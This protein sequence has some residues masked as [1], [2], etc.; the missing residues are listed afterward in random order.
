MFYRRSDLFG[1]ARRLCGRVTALG[2]FA[3]ACVMFGVGT[4]EA[5][6]TIDPNSTVPGTAPQP[7]N[8]PFFPG[9]GVIVL[10]SPEPNLAEYLFRYRCCATPGTP[11]CPSDDN[12]FDVYT[13]VPL[14]VEN[15][16]SCQLISH[17]DPNNGNFSFRPPDGAVL[18]GA[19]GGVNVNGMGGNR[20]NEL[21]RAGDVAGPSAIT[22]TP[23]LAAAGFKVEDTTDLVVELPGQDFV[24]SRTF[25]GSSRVIKTSAFGPHALGGWM[26]STDIQIVPDLVPAGSQISEDK[27]NRSGIALLVAAPVRDSIAFQ[28]LTK[29][30]PEHQLATTT[31]DSVLPT[32]A[33][34][35]DSDVLRTFRPV[36]PGMMR[37]IADKHTARD[38]VVPTPAPS[39]G[40]Q[41][42]AFVP[43]DNPSNVV[44]PVWRLVDPGNGTSIFFR[45]DQRGTAFDSGLAF[46]PGASGNG[47]DDV[48]NDAAAE[49]EMISKLCG[50]YLWQQIDAYGNTW[51]YEYTNFQVSDGSTQPR[52]TAIYLHGKSKTDSSTRAI[53]RFYWDYVKARNNE[54]VIDESDIFAPSV[55]GKHLRIRMVTVERPVETV[56]G[57]NS[58]RSWETTDRI[59]YYY[60]GNVQ[61]HNIAGSDSFRGLGSVGDLVMVI[62]RT[63]AGQSEAVINIPESGGQTNRIQSWH[64]RITQYRMINTIIPT[65]GTSAIVSKQI[66]SVFSPEQIELLAMENPRV[67]DGNGDRI[68][69][70]NVVG[71]SYADL[72]ENAAWGLLKLP[73]REKLKFRSSPV[74]LGSWSQE[75]WT[76]AAKWLIYYNQPGFYKVDG[77]GYSGPDSIDPPADQNSL[78]F[79]GRVREELLMPGPRGHTLRKQHNYSLLDDA[80]SD[81]KIISRTSSQ[82][83]GE[84]SQIFQNTITYGLRSSIT[85]VSEFTR[86]TNQP[87]LQKTDLWSVASAAWQ[88]RRRVTH[89]SEERELF[90]FSWL[91]QGENGPATN[92]W[93]AAVVPFTVAE[94]VDE[95]DANGS[96]VVSGRTWLTYYE[97]DKNNRPWR[98][99]DPGALYSLVGDLGDDANAPRMTNLGSRIANA[100][101]SSPGLFANA[102]GSISS[103]VYA[104]YVQPSDQL[105]EQLNCVHN[106]PATMRVASRFVGRRDSLALGDTN[107]AN[108]R[109][110]TRTKYHNDVGLLNPPIRGINYT[111]TGPIE[112]R[113]DLPTEDLTFTSDTG[114][115]T[116]DNTERTVYTWNARTESAGSGVHPALK[117]SRVQSVIVQ[118]EREL[119]G[120][121]GPLQSGGRAVYT[122]TWLDEI[123]RVRA[124]SVYSSASDTSAP[125]S[126]AYSYGFGANNQHDLTGKPTAVRVGVTIGAD[127]DLLPIEESTQTLT[128]RSVFDVSGNLIRSI[129]PNGIS[130]DVI[131]SVQ[132]LPTSRL[133]GLDSQAMPVSVLV[134]TVIPHEMS[135][136]ERPTEGLSLAGAITQEWYNAAFRPLRVTTHALTPGAVIARSTNRTVLAVPVLDPFEFSRADTVYTFSGLSM[137]S[138]TWAFTSQNPVF[139]SVVPPDQ[140]PA[141]MQV[142]DEP[143]AYVTRSDY[144]GDGNVTRS[145]DPLGNVFLSKYDSRARLIQTHRGIIAD[146]GDDTTLVEERF[147]DHQTELSPPNQNDIGDGLLTFIKTYPGNGIAPRSVK[148]VYDARKRL[149][150]SF[151][152]STGTNPSFGP[153]SLSLYD[154]LDRV[155]LK[156][157]LSESV[158]HSAAALRGWSESGVLASANA[159][160][161]SR[162]FYSQRGFPFR[163]QS[164]IGGGTQSE[165]PRWSTVD[166]WFDAIGR[167]LAVSS[168]GG[169]T[170]K[171]QYDA[172]GQL[173]RRRSV[174]GGVANYADALHIDKGFGLEET[175]TERSN[176][177]TLTRLVTRRVRVDAD[178]PEAGIPSDGMPIG[179]SNAVS[180][181]AATYYDFAARPILTINYGTNDTSASRFSSI[182]VAAPLRRDTPIK[183]MLDENLG[184]DVPQHA[185]VTGVWYDTRGYPEVSAVKTG[186]DAA[187]GRIQWRVT[188][189]LTDSLG[190]VYAVIENATDADLTSTPR[191]SWPSAGSTWVRGSVLAGT[192]DQNRL[193]TT[194]FDSGGQVVRT[195]A[196][197]G[198]FPEA[199]QTTEYR[200]GGSAAGGLSADVVSSNSTL[201]E[202]RY[203]DPN[204][205]EPS[206]SPRDRVAYSYNG[207]GEQQ[208][209][210]DQNGTIR[211]FTRDFQG[212]VIADTVQEFG[213]PVLVGT[214]PNESSTWQIDRRVSQ[215][216]TKFDEF[217][218][219]KAVASTSWFNNPST[220]AVNSGSYSVSNNVDPTLPWRA[221]SGSAINTSDKLADSV[222]YEY[223][224]IGLVKTIR[225]STVGK[226]PD[227][228]A[229][230]PQSP[231]TEGV[232]VVEHDYEIVPIAGDPIGRASIRPKWMKYPDIDTGPLSA[233]D[234]TYLHTLYAN[235]FHG[236]IDRPTKLAVTASSSTPSSSTPATVEYKRLGSGTFVETHF[237]GGSKVRM[238]R[239]TTNTPGLYPGWDSFGRLR[240]YSWSRLVSLPNNSTARQ[241][242]YGEQFR[243]DILSRK[244]TSFRTMRN[245]GFRS[246]DWY[247]QYDALDRVLSAERGLARTTFTIGGSTHP[248]EEIA[249][250]SKQWSLD[251]LGNWQNEQTVQGDGTTTTSTRAHNAT[252]EVTSIGDESRLYD[253]NGNVVEVVQAGLTPASRQRLVYDAWNR[254]VLREVY[255]GAVP[256]GSNNHLYHRVRQQYNALNWRTVET[257]EPAQIG[258]T[259]PQHT[260]RRFYYS[261]AWQVLAEEVRR[262]TPGSSALPTNTLEHQFWGLR[263]VD[264]AILRR[265]DRN[266]N[267]LTDDPPNAS[268]SPAFAGDTQYNQLVDSNMSVVGH[269]DALTG[270]L[271][272]RM[273]YD[274]YGRMRLHLNADFNGDGRVDEDD[275]WQFNIAY[276]GEYDD[277]NGGASADVNGD[278]GVNEA[279][280]DLFSAWYE[281]QS[282]KYPPIDDVRVAYH[283]YIPEHAPTLSSVGISRPTEAAQVTTYLGRMRWY[284]ANLGR[285]LT[286]DPAGYVDGLNVYQFVRS[287]P[288]M[289]VD[290]TGLFISYIFGGIAESAEFVWT[291]GGNIERQMREQ[292]ELDNRTSRLRTEARRRANET[293]DTTKVMTVYQTQGMTSKEITAQSIAAADNAVERAE[294]SAE[295]VTTLAGGAGDA[296]QIIIDVAQNGVSTGTVVNAVANLGPSGAGASLKKVPLPKVHV[297]GTGAV[298]QVA[299]G[300]ANAAGHAPAGAVSTAGVGVLL[301]GVVKK[302]GNTVGDQY[303]E[304]YKKVDKDGNFLKWG[305]SKDARTRYTRKQLD[306][307]DAI[308]V[309]TGTRKEIIKKER[310]LVETNPGPENR[311]RWAGKRKPNN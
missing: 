30:Y 75:L 157:T 237:A 19:G 220:G 190:R 15:C 100:N 22:N 245:W 175:V 89:R 133:N 221:S 1:F 260:R 174:I 229:S 305:V 197:L 128:S 210:I 219:T 183:S 32:P 61:D 184:F 228:T 156:A 239:G 227:P 241:V 88:P 117:F 301:P 158:D 86:T 51:N 202:I 113:P 41:P 131:F 292:N 259:V 191:P 114:S 279:D 33:Y 45:G 16:F 56:G 225:Q 311:E 68:G 281:A 44:L 120:E 108:S 283:G 9:I 105:V 231:F 11:N 42:A 189:T 143:R 165:P 24:L 93:W 159:T 102:M 173:I 112:N 84:P 310:D 280:L 234:D 123:G 50:G 290:P 203:P 67:N 74:E 52:V 35:A 151:A 40:N 137:L 72:T 294:G 284:E 180:T 177:S 71:G 200:Y 186:V 256:S 111:F 90:T 193:T 31:S 251:T 287:N 36:G 122:K 135:A 163:S 65:N 106:Y 87:F 59:E 270:E 77:S 171:S 49:A 28:N 104:D 267:G 96:S 168:T 154:N 265:I 76:T 79:M 134:A 192:S 7:V 235:P 253:S 58:G 302:H 303:A 5:G 162:M 146:T 48:V 199:T 166:R 153:V 178:M 293:G 23:V 150:S 27:W 63:R 83:L 296:A 254:L 25:S 242:V 261:G 2:L 214:P 198:G 17:T 282:V 46:T 295:V 243:Y 20:K 258:S 125:L 73:D 179:G 252:N 4:S 278:G 161:I 6:D 39:E 99:Y 34:S 26:L 211:K 115:H 155:R 224:R 288:L 126:T 107:E 205:G 132:P 255:A 81:A 187:T 95:L 12:C 160:G 78:L 43:N 299:A 195:T 264:E 275:L 118:R 289:F 47:F 97:F 222:E 266:G 216:I 182:G 194:V 223:T 257:H 70:L 101:A 66:R 85:R 304:L 172:A 300:L 38:P 98:T 119:E 92:N 62:S 18:G 144:D 121:N 188:R 274:L 207:V 80:G 140:G 230:S 262:W 308:V 152:Q 14:R 208:E 196:H 232:R 169:P 3:C 139:P 249:P 55:D 238:S 268:A 240:T 145:Q 91:R 309:D 206:T 263:N 269:V 204:T 170:I 181:Y 138:R 277:G 212:R 142:N 13:T 286:R 141:P 109:E 54:V 94:R 285:W 291:G 149:V 226:V 297:P 273:S 248:L 176:N 215:L 136:S 103:V 306:G 148:S 60:R 307:G 201:R 82:R 64:A 276:L 129:D 10:P 217:G 298:T 110:I 57:A 53:V 271:R 8:L 233:A 147:Y 116:D 130:S 236:A 69:Q 246:Q 124:S 213:E 37:L 127:E 167:E 185:Q 29:Y 244:Q 21:L 164:F 218:R 272:Q 209:I 247:F 250:E